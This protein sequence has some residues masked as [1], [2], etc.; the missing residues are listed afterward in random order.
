MLKKTLLLS[1]R[2]TFILLI[3]ILLLSFQKGKELK[4]TVS[5][6]DGKTK[7]DNV[8]AVLYESDMQMIK[9]KQ[10]KTHKVNAGTLVLNLELKK[11][12]LIEFK[13]ED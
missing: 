12:F 11:Q 13:K 4:L 2:F 3:S 9:G 1:V 7:L 10:L 8:N 5:V 6:K